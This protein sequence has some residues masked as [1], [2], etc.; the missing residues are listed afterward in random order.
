M[1][2]QDVNKLKNSLSLIT[3]ITSI[4]IEGSK[5]TKFTAPN[6][7]IIN[8]FDTGTVTFQGN[9]TGEEQKKLMKN[10]EELI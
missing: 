4:R 8:V 9:T 1:K 7:L 2:T 3:G 5:N 10:I 6:S